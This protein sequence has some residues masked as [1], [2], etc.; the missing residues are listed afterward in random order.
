MALANAYFEDQRYL[1]AADT[2]E[3][4]R[5]A[6]PTSQHQYDAHLLELRSRIEA[7]QGSAYDGTHLQKA[8]KLLASVMKQ[9]PTEI[10][11]DREELMKIAAEVRFRLA[12]RD[13]KMARYYD[14]SGQYRSATIYY[15]EIVDKYAG[16]PQADEAA[17]RIAAI[18]DKPAKP[19]QRAQWLVDLFPEADE[20]KPLIPS[21][22][23][24]AALK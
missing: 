4:L 18:S 3:D 5:I 8:D 10:D 11:R 20:M 23:T 21:S 17:E 14:Y 24:A 16:T 15:Q 1:D 2:Y 6:F 19:P 13:M 22:S 9:F 12:Q 7:Y